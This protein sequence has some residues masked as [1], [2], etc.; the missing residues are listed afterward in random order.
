MSTTASSGTPV[1][2]G[3]LGRL[4]AVG[5]PKL[6]TTL[7]VAAAVIALVGALTTDGFATTAN[8][9]AI[10]ASVGSV[11]IV[12]VGMSLIIIG[13]NL[14]S[15]ALAPTLAVT[16][17]VLCSTLDDGWI[18]A[19]ALAFGFAVVAG[20][21]QG[22]FAGLFEVNPVILT[23]AAS[24]LLLGLGVLISDEFV[25]TP[26]GT[27]FGVL[28]DTVIG[29]P[30]TVYVMVALAIAVE[31][32]LQFT[33]FGRQ[34]YLIGANRRAAHAAGLPVARITLF[35]FIGASVCAAIGGILL[36]A[37]NKG[38]GTQLEGTLTYDALA[39]VLVGGTPLTGGEG[40]ISRTIV[41][42]VIVAVITNVLLLRGFD[43]GVRTL[44]TG[45]LLLVVILG[46][47]LRLAKA[48]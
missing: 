7:I 43:E 1:S 35:V 14:F 26:A 29:V 17:I 31:C 44:A 48:R 13:G 25:Q 30:F 2:P 47:Q 15:L 38:G 40:S 34:V 23:L 32:I 19:L 20:A 36:S 9:K 18:V 41:G 37:V 27:S 33:R 22:L 8:F 39:A 28:D 21:G 46:V 42:T 11:G 5:R 24:S 10:L 3:G 16:G 6:T 45:V 4:R 12:A